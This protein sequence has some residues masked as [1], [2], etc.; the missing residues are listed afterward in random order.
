MI[1][2]FN[3]AFAK[4]VSVE[5]GYVDDKND[6][7]GATKFGISQRSYP[8]VD[9]KNLTLDQAKEIYRADY[10][11]PVHGDELPDPLS[12]FVFDAAVNQGVSHAIYMLQTALKVTTDGKIGEKTIAA[13][14]ASNNEACANFMMLRSFRYMSTINF[15]RYG[16]GWMNRL[17]FMAM[18]GV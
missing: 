3:F 11:N 1:G 8:D 10:W 6:P 13:A 2:S 5:G 9:I 12:H 17:F 18:G 7:G 4:V 15:G 16:P 14:R